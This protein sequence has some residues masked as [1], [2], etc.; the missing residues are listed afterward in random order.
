MRL[1]HLMAAAQDT[2][3]VSAIAGICGRY[4]MPTLNSLLGSLQD[5]SE[6]A[7]AFADEEEMSVADIKVRSLDTAFLHC[8]HSST[9]LHPLNHSPYGGTPRLHQ[10]LCTV[11]VNDRLTGTLICRQLCSIPCLAQ[12]EACQ[13]AARF[14]L[15]SMSSSP[16]W[17]PRTQH[18]L[19][20]RYEASL[21]NNSNHC[22]DG[23]PS[24]YASF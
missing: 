3:I 4:S 6:F 7:V 5:P 17:R 14:V 18:L 15:R 22:S 9:W 8:L 23:C 21:A 2:G 12:K 1:T 19:P 24:D 10:H 13:L 11:S 16:S 20:Q